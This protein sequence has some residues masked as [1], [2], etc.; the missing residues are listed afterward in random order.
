VFKN[1]SGMHYVHR[2]FEAF[3]D[4]DQDLA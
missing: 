2:A 1:V 4:P 3:D